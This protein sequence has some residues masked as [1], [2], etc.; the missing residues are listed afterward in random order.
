MTDK[1]P[2]KVEKRI[3]LT[4]TRSAIHLPSRH[5]S[6]SIHKIKS[7][8]NHQEVIRETI[9]FFAQIATRPTGSL[10]K[11]S[12]RKSQIILRPMN[13]LNYLNNG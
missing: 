5:H 3:K 6:L 8:E 4:N 9:D 11:K 10:I 1:K 13:S 7:T 12:S 2:R